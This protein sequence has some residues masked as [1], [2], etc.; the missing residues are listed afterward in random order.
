MNE[1]D[2]TIIGAGPAGSTLARLL[3]E[4]YK[5]LL[6]DKRSLEDF[7][8]TNSCEKCCGGL[9]A[10]DAQKVLAKL[11]LGVPKEVLTGPQP[12]TVKTIDFDND[13]ERFYQRHYINIDRERFDS[14]L[15][16][17]IPSHVQCRFSCHYHSFEDEG[18]LLKLRLRNGDGEFLVKTK[19][20]VGADGAISRVRNQAFASAPQPEKYGSIQEWFHTDSKV[21][22]FMSIFDQ[23][24]TDFYSWAIQK[25]NMLILGTAVPAENGV[26]EKFEKLKL[27]MKEKGYNL[28][29]PFKRRGT[30]IFRPT[31]TNQIN[32]GNSKVA[33]VGEAAGFISPSSAEGISYALR[34]AISLAESLNSDFDNFSKLYKRR[35]KSLKRNIVLKNLKS[36]VMYTPFL[37]KLVMKSR[38]LAME[39]SE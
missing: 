23:S 5:V 20:L 11:G 7:E 14:W 28:S 16:S 1:Y 30:L 10:P 9:L 24:I 33:L 17:L 27:K 13:L 2:V 12:F 8:S 4:K 26:K 3:S 39:V 29:A 15:V 25:E 6:V 36:I 32:L 22:Y 19:V 37:R 18:D 31:K 21:P 35:S 38:Y 34:S